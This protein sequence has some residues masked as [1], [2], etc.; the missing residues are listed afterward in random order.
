MAIDL[1]LDAA[2]F[3]LGV[4]LLDQTSGFRYPGMKDVYKTKSF[5]C[6]SSGTRR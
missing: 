1:W 2:G 3:G 4:H 6:Q 5:R